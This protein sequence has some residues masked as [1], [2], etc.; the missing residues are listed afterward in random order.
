MRQR[1]YIQPASGLIRREGIKSRTH[2][3]FSKFAPAWTKREHC[4]I[5]VISLEWSSLFPRGI[6]RDFCAAAFARGK[7]EIFNRLIPCYIVTWQAWGRF[8]IDSSSSW[9]SSAMSTINDIIYILSFSATHVHWSLIQFKGSSRKRRCRFQ[10][11]HQ[12]TVPLI[13]FKP[14]WGKT[15]YNIL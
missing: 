5:F 13:S 15:K 3:L 11:E 12:G 6:W 4:L 9:S 10:P 7:P 1:Y 14:I 8:T 2:R